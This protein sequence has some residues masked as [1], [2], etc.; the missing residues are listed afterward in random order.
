MQTG[1][2]GSGV[3][4]TGMAQVIAAAGHEVTMVNPFA[5]SL[6]EARERHRSAMARLVSKGRIERDA[7]DALL[8]RI[9]YVESLPEPGGELLAALSDCGMVIEAIVERLD[10]KQDLFRKLEP[11]VSRDTV[12]ASNTSSLAVAAIAGVCKNPERVIGVHFFNPAPLMPLVEVIPAITTAREVADSVQKLVES[13]GKTA[14]RA[15]DTPG[16]LVNR[17]ARPFYGEALRIAE[18]CIADPATI[19]HALRTHGGFR[20]GPFE[21]MDFIGHDVNFAVTSS[22]F[23][24]TF[25]DPRYRPSILQQ[26]LV[27]SGRLGRKTGVGFYTYDGDGRAIVPEPSGSDELHEEILLRVLVMLINEAVEYVH[28]G[29]ATASDVELAMTK[30]VNYPQGLLAWGDTLGPARVLAR[31]DALYRDTGD[32]RYRASVSLR[33]VVEQR[34]SIL[35]YISKSQVPR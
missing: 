35:D 19:D 18:E 1:V 2:V 10:A 17:V 24:A 11:L 29:L 5:P 8:A 7:A 4:A 31:L 15:S 21:L 16:F 6:A 20:M 14:V 23:A 30:G 13:W 25:S 32:M 33:R 28:L 12:L 22:V 34:S 26:R 9:R 3:M 27:E